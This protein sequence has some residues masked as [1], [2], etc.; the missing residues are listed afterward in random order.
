MTETPPFSRHESL[1]AARRAAS[2]WRDRIAALARPLAAGSG[3]ARA[4]ATDARFSA[5]VR[6][7]QK[8]AL[9]GRLAAGLTHDFNNALLVADACL[10]LLV[11]HA[12]D[13]AM[14]RE[15]AQEASAAIRRASELARRLATFGRPDSGTRL[16]V[17]LNEVVRASARLVEPVVRPLVDLSVSC[18]PNALPVSVD[19]AQIE[20]AILN[21][22]LN[23]RDAMPDGGTLHI[24]TRS[25]IRWTQREG[26]G[27]RVPVT[28]AVVEVT[29][30]GSGIP[31]DVQGRVFEPF[32]TTK[33]PGEGSGLGLPMVNETV[34][35]HAGLV[36]LTSD[37][38]GTAFRILL[39]LA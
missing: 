35:A 29:D 9:A 28:Y 25:A 1:H 16:P 2:T 13:P 6:Q 8:L 27:N 38:M 10:D 4:M 23:A 5:D 22:C 19:P 20:Q 7:M 36:E 15:Q 11:E 30:T 17:D 14:V 31:L 3:T 39:P 32:F 26:G 21:L 33:A 24:A 37:A 18:P 12:D 34:L